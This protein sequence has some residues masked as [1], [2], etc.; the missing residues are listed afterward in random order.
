MTHWTRD[1]LG[2]RYAARGRSR[3]GIDCWGLV[4]LVYR[5]QLGVELPSYDDEKVSA[6]EKHEAE[7][8][9]RGEMGKWSDVPAEEAR[10]FDVLWMRDPHHRLA[11]HVG[12]VVRPGLMLH[13]SSNQQSGSERG[14]VST[15]DY[16]C[17]LWHRLLIGVRRH[18]A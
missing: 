12:I 9:F 10:E 15:A 16:D 7:A 14:V 4:C 17:G 18:A 11:T 6:E 2:L 8:L 3:E 5:E 1:Y 13:A